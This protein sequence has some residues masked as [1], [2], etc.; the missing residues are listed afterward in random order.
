MLPRAGTHRSHALHTAASYAPCA[1]PLPPHLSCVEPITSAGPFNPDRGGALHRPYP[2]PTATA[3]NT[4]THNVPSPAS[5]NALSTPTAL[6]VDAMATPSPRT[7]VTHAR[8]FALA[9]HQMRM[10]SSPTKTNKQHTKLAKPVRTCPSHRARPIP[11]C[12]A[13]TGARAALESQVVW[14]S[15]THPTYLPVIVPSV[16]LHH[17]PRPACFIYS[18]ITG[19]SSRRAQ[20]AR[21]L[22]HVALRWHPDAAAAA[23][24]TVGRQGTANGHQCYP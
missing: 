12:A 18:F 8:P 20:V 17:Q 21:R 11:L 4:S 23:A 15:R 10:Q 1:S 19:G 7:P 14:S 5:R 3:R 16:I 24:G 22:L 9:G 13:C 6:R 2:N